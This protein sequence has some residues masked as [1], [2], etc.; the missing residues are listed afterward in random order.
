MKVG[1]IPTDT[2]PALVCD[3]EN[4]EAVRVMYELKKA[5]PSTK[6][7]SILC[8]NFQDITTYTSG[9]QFQSFFKT[10]KR[11]LPGPYTLILP[12]SK[13][14]PKQITDFDAGK[15]KKRTAVGVRLVDNVIC[16]ALMERLE[17]PL[18]S[19]SAILPEMRDKEGRASAVPDIGALM[20]SYGPA[21]G[22]VIGIHEDDVLQGEAELVEGSTVLDLTGS[23]I[24]VV[25]YGAG[26][27]SWL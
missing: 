26:D 13:N 25:R 3:L 21:L 23:E 6:S 20:D 1:I 10:A 15:S 12:A 11:I 8:R 16:A 18:L 22:F 5:S 9:S 4:K 19:S 24:E 17:R 2:Y 14:L 27:V 7:M